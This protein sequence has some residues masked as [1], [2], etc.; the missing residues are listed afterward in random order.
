MDAVEE[1]WEQTLCCVLSVQVMHQPVPGK[2]YHAPNIT[3]SG[4]RLNAVDNLPTLEAHSLEMPP[5][6]R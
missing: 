3:V 2:S 4:H 1:G 6:C 5:Y